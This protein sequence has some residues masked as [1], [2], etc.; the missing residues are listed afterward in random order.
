MNRSLYALLPA[1]LMLCFGCRAPY[2][3]PT[4]RKVDPRSIP[5]QTA[6]APGT[7]T[8]EV[9]AN[10]HRYR[11]T[12]LAHYAI[13]ARVLSRERYYF[14]WRADLSPIDLALGWGALADPGVDQ[15]IDWHQ[16]GRW[17]F[18]DWSADS[19][20]RNEDI[21]PQ[22]ANVH[23]IPAND[24]VR[25]VLFSIARDQ[26]VALSGQ[27]VRVDDRLAAESGGWS[28]SLSRT[29]TGDGSCE[30]MYVERVVTDGVEY[31]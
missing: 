27:L 8:L 28:S 5:E 17:Y 14:G 6:V 24:N 23:I 19:P 25:S 10:E 7:A 21:I 22:S 9:S 20:Y 30:L 18:F 13:A 2:G 15:F 29:D 4:Q 11:L 12:P 26:V 31:W 16:A 1:A 3:T